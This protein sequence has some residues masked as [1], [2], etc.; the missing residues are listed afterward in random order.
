[1]CNV[2]QPTPEM[3][4]RVADLAVA[5]IP[6]YLIC[7]IIKIDDDTLNKYY[8]HELDTAQSEV[9]GRIA[10]TVVMQAEAGDF[11]SQSLFLKTQA[12]KFGWVE[13]QVV[14]TVS[15]EETQALQEK[16]KELEGKYDK[17]Y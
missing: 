17:D 13:K 7:K 10:K 14:E 1:M 11:K 8:S 4:Q 15:A 16:I 12:A 6:K 3:R 5:G 9:V 2:H